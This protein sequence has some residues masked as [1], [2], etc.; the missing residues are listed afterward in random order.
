MDIKNLL[1]NGNFTK[2]I[3]Y[4]T[5]ENVDYVA[6]DGDDFLGVAKISTNGYIQQK[7]TASTKKYVLSFAVRS[8][9]ET[10]TITV[11]IK[12]SS[13]A[14]VVSKTISVTDVWTINEIKLPLP[15]G[16]YYLKISYA[17]ASFVNVDSIW[18]Y[19]I[20]L[21]RM[22]IAKQVHEKLGTYVSAL[23]F[24]YTPAFTY[25]VDGKRLE[26]NSEGSYTSSIN[27]QLRNFD[28]FDEN[29]VIDIRFLSADKTNSFIDAVYDDMLQKVLKHYSLL[30]DENHGGSGEKLSQI[31]DNAIKISGSKASDKKQISFAKIIYNRE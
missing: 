19:D 15:G 4:W 23:S 27:S 31:L 11:E 5:R 3:S 20:S 14:V 8:N 28:A 25:D 17:G 18:I 30:T 13:D 7:F 10:D 29:G 22:E 6:S 16:S 1:T 12:N 26:S 2:N 21:S 24:T 9:L